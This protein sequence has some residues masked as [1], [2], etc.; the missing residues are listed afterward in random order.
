[1]NISCYH[2]EKQTPNRNSSGC[3]KFQQGFTARQNT[4]LANSGAL[5]NPLVAGFHVCG[6][7]V[8]GNNLIWKG[9]AGSNNFQ[10]H[11]TLSNPF[12]S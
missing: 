9:R 12:Q 1:M 4:P 6:K 8:I 5:G 11:N 7:I 2:I 10:S 3:T